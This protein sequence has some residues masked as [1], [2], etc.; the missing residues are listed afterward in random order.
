LS[1]SQPS[2]AMKTGVVATI[3]A[4]VVAWAVVSPVDCSH[5]WKAIPIYPSSAI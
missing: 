4:V 1:A 3:Q 2:S 5:W